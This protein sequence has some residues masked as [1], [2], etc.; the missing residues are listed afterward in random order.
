MKI[1]AVIF[2]LMTITACDYADE[3]AMKYLRVTGHPDATCT[4]NGQ[5]R[6]VCSSQ[7]EQFDCLVSNSSGCEAQSQVMCQLKQAER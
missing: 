7:G 6:A 4:R 2:G 1:Y 3:R 5:D